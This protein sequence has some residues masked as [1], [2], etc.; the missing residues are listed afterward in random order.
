MAIVPIP[1]VLENKRGAYTIGLRLL[2]S[3]KL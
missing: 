3:K 2:P 1:I